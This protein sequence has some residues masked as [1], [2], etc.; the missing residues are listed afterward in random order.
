MKYTLLAA[1]AL[2]APSWAQLV[3]ED[4]E[5]ANTHVWS[6]NG[7]T[8]ATY[9]AT[10]GNPNGN[11]GVTNMGNSSQT[12][13]NVDLLLPT[14]AGHPWSGDFRLMGVT[15]FSYDREW[16]SGGSPFGDGTTVILADNNG[17]PSIF[18]DDAFLVVYTGQFLGFGT[19]NAWTSV[20]VSIPSADSTLPS[21][22]EA[23]TM[24]GSP[25]AGLDNDGL[26]NAIITDVDYI[27]LAVNSPFNFF[28]VGVHNLNY[29]NF[30]LDN[31][32]PTVGTP[33]CDPM[34]PNSTTQS[35]TMTGNMSNPGGSGLHL[36]AFNGPAGEFGYFLV[37]TASQDPGLALSDG[38]LCL[39]T[40]G[41]NAVGRYNVSGGSLNSVGQ[42]N[43]AG[44]YANIVGTSSS[45]LGYDVPSTV[46]IPGSPTI[47]SGQTWHF[48]LWH[49]D[50]PAGTG[51]SNFSNGLS[52]TF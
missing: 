17:T 41:G 8:T 10:G 13:V 37:G 35:T 26:W 21:G 46:P 47:M 18:N 31:T 14:S 30:Q 38:F 52:V 12:N 1:A 5:T 16:V 33:F 42:F 29:D 34:A 4:F 44:V 25:M 24:P 39:S 43:A 6:V 2:I 9:N 28:P 23:G 15:G 3:T 27:A 40:T 32:L 11:I 20:S 45:G 50:T 49:R 36:D 7:M 19:S 48:Q 22:W 51:H